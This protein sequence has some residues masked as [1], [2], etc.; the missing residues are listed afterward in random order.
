MSQIPL[1]DDGHAAVLERER[2]YEL[3]R[4]PGP[5]CNQGLVWGVHQIVGWGCKVPRTMLDIGAG[6]GVFGQQLVLVHRE[7]AERFD[8]G[9][10][11][12]AA[13]EP[14]LEETPH[15]RRLY[16]HLYLCT[17][18]K[19]MTEPSDL[20]P[21]LPRLWVASNPAFSIFPDIV[22]ACA[23]VCTATLLY[24]SIAW[25]CSEAG[26]ELFEEH[27]PVACGRV[28]GRVHHRGPGHNPKTGEPWGADQRDN[29]WW[30]WMRDHRPDH[31][32][33]Y[34]LPLLPS[35]QRRWTIPPG[36]EP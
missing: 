28:I 25:G 4:T 20:R 1:I 26:A 35:E 7:H 18:G 31:W 6:S 23:P 8:E 2:G 15:L 13:I 14:R 33:T 27:R 30:L 17:F 34:N 24:G 16:E 29:C 11:Q 19:W 36:Q 5:V 9:R 12:C 10:L 3:D 21:H 22:R 32:M